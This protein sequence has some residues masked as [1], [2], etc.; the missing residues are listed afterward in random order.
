MRKD[1]GPRDWVEPMPVLVLGTY[2]PDGKPNAMTA[3]WGGMRRYEPP[4]LDVHITE[5]QKTA[6][7]LRAGS[8]LVV[9]LTTTATMEAADYVGIATGNEV[10]KVAKTGWT[11]KKSEFVNAPVFQ[12]FPLAL[13]CKVLDVDERT[14]VLAQ[15]INVSVDE[16]YLNGAG[17]PDIAKMDLIVFDS[18]NQTYRKLG[19]VAGDAYTVGQALL[20]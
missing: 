12:E 20:K 17:Q 15:I 4:C 13:E 9:H 1:F 14:T 5:T 2:D 3:A 18:T 8:D 16:E 7:N 6:K 11:V 19:D 10:D